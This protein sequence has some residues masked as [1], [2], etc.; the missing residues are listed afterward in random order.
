MG[1]DGKWAIHPSQ[2]EPL[3]IAFQPTTEERERA[4]AVLQ[5]LDEARA[6][7]QGAARL[8]GEMIDE[9]HRA[10]ALAVLSRTDPRR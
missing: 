3:N 7:G 5:A 9:A 8:D 4:E 10:R 6:A 2:V 1:F